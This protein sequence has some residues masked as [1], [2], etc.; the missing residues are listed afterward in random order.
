MRERHQYAIAHAGIKAGAY[1]GT[2]GWGHDLRGV[3]DVGVVRQRFGIQRNGV[4]TIGGHVRHGGIAAEVSFDARLV[5]DVRPVRSRGFHQ[6][7]RLT[8]RLA[9]RDAI[10]MGNHAA[11]HTHVQGLLMLI[12]T[13]SCVHFAIGRFVVGAQ[14]G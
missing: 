13:D 12:L 5:R 11:L 10:R 8:Q 2:A 6:R 1:H 4:V 3:G 14:A 9:Q 7:D